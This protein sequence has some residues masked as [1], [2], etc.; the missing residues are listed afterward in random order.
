MTYSLL[1]RD[2]T[3]GDIG[4]AVQSHFFAVGR[5]VPWAAAGVGAVATQAIVEP[6]YGSQGLELMGDGVAPQEALAQLVEQ[7]PDAGLRQVA[8]MAS[9]G[10]VAAHTGRSCIPAAGHTTD[11]GLSAHANLVESET[12]WPA[13]ADAFQAAHGNLARRMLTAL[14]AAEHQGG[15]IRG[16]QAAAMIIVP[17]TPTGQLA[18]DRL[19]DL[20]VDDAT[21][22]LDELERLINHADAFRGLLEMLQTEG[23]LNGEHTAEAAQ[24]RH[25]LAELDAAQHLVGEHNPEPTVW[26]GLLLARS[27]RETDARHAFHHAMRM[28]PR[29]PEL[30]RRLGRTGMW[31]GDPAALD[32]LLTP[33][34]SPASSTTST[35]AVSLTPTAPEP[36]TV[37]VRPD[38]DGKG[39][40]MPTE[41]QDRQEILE[42][43]RIWWESN[44]KLVIPDMQSVFPSGMSYLMFNLNGHPYFGIEEKTKLWEHYQHELDI[45]LYPDMEIMRLE[46]SGDMAWLAC[47]GIFPVREIGASGTGSATWELAE[48]DYTNFRIRATEIYQR[49]DGE[50]NPVWKMWHFHTSPMP[51]G[52]E[53]RPGVGG[54]Q[55]Q[56]GIGYGPGITPVRATHSGTRN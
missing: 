47:E 17:A 27:G 37:T 54:S 8:L 12:V 4:V 36:T 14:R 40:Q 34:D 24:T 48:D 23:L 41:D 44:H 45:V 56:R 21:D 39:A 32:V 55:N 30:V 42:L 43:H 19:I 15:D 26:K 33:A 11:H 52:D 6:S 3:N 1:A 50:G 46:I 20:R 22:P 38:W 49:D 28:E 35:G 18:Q 10:S 29:T 2:P 5:L 51:D 7:D 25:A 13:M 9:D 31:P 16:R 53:E